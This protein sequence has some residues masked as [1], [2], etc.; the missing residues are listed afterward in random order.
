MGDVA[1]SDEAF[2]G[3]FAGTAVVEGTAAG[4]PDGV[5]SSG[6]SIIEEEQSEGAVIKAEAAAG[7]GDSVVA[8]AAGGEGRPR[9]FLRKG[10]CMA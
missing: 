3:C 10:R 7:K 2:L 6:Q 1:R 9:A 5:L 4:R 8:G